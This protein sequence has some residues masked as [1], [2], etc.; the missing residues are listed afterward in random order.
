MKAF[1]EASGIKNVAGFVWYVRAG[2]VVEVK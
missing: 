1:K 2:K